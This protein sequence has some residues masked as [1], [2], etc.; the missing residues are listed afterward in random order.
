MPY[1]IIQNQ[2]KSQK[3]TSKCR[4]VAR[5]NL[6]FW[7]FNKYCIFQ[8]CKRRKLNTQI[9]IATILTSRK[10]CCGRDSITY[11]FS[12][13]IQQHNFQEN[14]NAVIVWTSALVQYLYPVLI[15]T[16]KIMAGTLIGESD[17]REREHTKMKIKATQLI[18]SIS[19]WKIIF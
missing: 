3:Y 5:K 15:N 10:I 2:C 4:Y 9:F 16:C 6:F 13:K 18:L 17:I 11:N 7:S 19:F 14:K 1:D 12:L 8:S